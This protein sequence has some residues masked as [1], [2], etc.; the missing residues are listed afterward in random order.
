MAIR[1]TRPYDAILDDLS[2]A[3]ADIP[4]FHTTF[5]M[6]RDEWAALPEGDKAVCVR[7]LADD[8]FYVLGGEST[9]APAGSGTVAYDRDH[10]II[11]VIASPSLVHIVNLRQQL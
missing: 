8:L 3:L 11:K 1:Y 6:D 4:D 5:E 9:T 7:T 2:R 10:G